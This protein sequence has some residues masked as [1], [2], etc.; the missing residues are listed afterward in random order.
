MF[1]QYHRMVRL[2][3]TDAA[4]V[5]YFAN[6]LSICHEAY[7]ASLASSNIHLQ[8]FFSN[9][10]TAVPIVHADI[11]YFHPLF[12]GDRLIISLQTE[13]E[14]PEKFH[15][16]YQVF[17]EDEKIAA[18]AHTI[19]V[20]IDPSTRTKQALSPEVTAWLQAHRH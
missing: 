5:V 4:G 8:T 2:A 20:C 9:S 1:Y 16:H 7:E 18:K 15:I 11:D 14:T 13:P 6:L 12:C 17:L 19:H 3:D 10:Q